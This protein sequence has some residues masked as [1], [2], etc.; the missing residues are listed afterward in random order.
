MNRN[1]PGSIDVNGVLKVDPV[2]IRDEVLT[3][4]QKQFTESWFNRPSLSGPFKSI[5]GDEARV[6]LE[7]EFTKSELVATIKDCD[8]NKALGHDG[9]N[10]LMFLKC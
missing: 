1:A 6:A 8:G 9:F 4:F 2:E 10:L 7:A 3:H 5:G